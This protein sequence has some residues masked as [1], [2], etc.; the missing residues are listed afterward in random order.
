MENLS[1][2]EDVSKAWENINEPSKMSAQGSLGLY[3]WKHHKPWFDEKHSRFL[4]KRQQ[5]KVQWLQDSNESNV[6][7]WNM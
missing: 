3:E 4:G 1:D 6:G 2:S 7:T 5:V